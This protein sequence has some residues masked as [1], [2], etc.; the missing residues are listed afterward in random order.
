[1]KKK[2]FVSAIVLSIYTLCIIGFSLADSQGTI[3]KIVDQVGL[4]NSELGIKQHGLDP[5]PD[6]PRPL[7]ERLTQTT[8][9]PVLQPI[10]TAGKQHGLD[11][12]PDPPRP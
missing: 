1:M 10:Q 2:L 3:T 5:V 7:T 8:S 4:S 12:V 11:P 6:P 9:D